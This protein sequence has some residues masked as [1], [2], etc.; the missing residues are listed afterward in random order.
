[1]IQDNQFIPIIISID[2]NICVGMHFYIQWIFLYAL[3]IYNETK[4]I[5]W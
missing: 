3:D 2:K 5:M 4:I 1:M